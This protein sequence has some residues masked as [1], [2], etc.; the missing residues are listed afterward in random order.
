[1]IRTGFNIQIIT[2]NLISDLENIVGGTI[3]DEED[4]NIIRQLTTM[5]IRSRHDDKI[6][7]F[8]NIEEES[9]EILTPLKI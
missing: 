5:Q 2:K 9:E 3:S 7:E 4:E 8:D 1:M 6:I